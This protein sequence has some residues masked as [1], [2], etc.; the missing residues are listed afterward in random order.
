MITSFSVGVN[1]LYYSVLS[2]DKLFDNHCLLYTIFFIDEEMKIC[3]INVHLFSKNHNA[4]LICSSK[5][6][7]NLIELIT[8]LNFTQ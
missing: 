3:L 2:W 7:T 5:G 4:V 1:S 8:P 6:R